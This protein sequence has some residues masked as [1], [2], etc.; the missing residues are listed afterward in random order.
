MSPQGGPGCSSFDGS[1]MEVG[2]FRT[3]PAA[4]SQSGQVELNLVQ[5][6]WEEFATIVF[7]VSAL[8]RARLECEL[9][10]IG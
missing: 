7:G 3:V 9:M 2:P 1:L 10:G 5:A 8:P 4:Q 6:G